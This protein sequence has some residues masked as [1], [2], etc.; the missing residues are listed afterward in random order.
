MD[1][2]R[3]FLEAVRAH[4]LAPGRLRGVFHVA[5]GRRIT[6]ADGTV[7]SAGVTW[8][9]LSAALKDLRFDKDLA[10]EVGADPDELSPRDRQR[11]WYSVIA[12]AQVNGARAAAEAEQ[13][14]AKV[15][16]LGYAVGR[17][18]VGTA[19]PG[20]KSSP[21]PKPSPSKPQAGKKPKKK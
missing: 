2:I 5:I 13:L 17:A 12:L 20:V 14:I 18:P 8:R 3:E 16:P 11:F 6:R 19:E 1:G 9:D 4:G 21:M 7:V 15:G 10:L